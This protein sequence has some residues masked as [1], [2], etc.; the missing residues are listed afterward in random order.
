LLAEER[1][2][3][4]LNSLTY[5]VTNKRIW[6]YGYVIMPNHVHI[7]WRKQP[8][9]L[10]K[11]VQQHFA[12][13]NGQQ[14]KFSLINNGEDLSFTKARKT[15]GNTNFGNAALTK[16]LC[17]T[18]LCWN[19]SWTVFIITPLKQIYV[20]YRRSIGIRRLGTTF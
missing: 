17:S 4:V 10:D 2:Q 13:F 18:G 15:T 20:Y 9:W 8:E 19:K 7:L 3:I 1:K 16:R 11:N 14:F 12:K 5:L 6:L